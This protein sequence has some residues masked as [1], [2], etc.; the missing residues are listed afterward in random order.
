MSRREAVRRGMNQS[1]VAVLNSKGKMVAEDSSPEEAYEK[2]KHASKKGVVVI[3]KNVYAGREN[4]PQKARK[5]AMQVAFKASK[6][7]AIKKSDWLV[8]PSTKAGKRAVTDARAVLNDAAEELYDG[9]LDALEDTI[10]TSKEARGVIAAQFSKAWLSTGLLRQNQKMA[11]ILAYDDNYDSIGLSL[12]PHGASFRPPFSTST[13][14]GSKGSSYCAFSTNECRK[15]CLVNTGQRA[16]ESGAFAASYLFSHLVREHPAEFMTN[17]LDQCL[18]AWRKAEDKGHG[19]FIRLNVLSDL[20]WEKIAPGFVQEVSELARAEAGVAGDWDMADGLAFYDYTKIPYR[21]GI[22]G[23]YDVTYSFTGRRDVSGADP[24]EH[25]ADIL[26]GERGVAKRAA[27]VFVQ[28][29]TTFQKQTGSY[30]KASAGSQLM[31][32]SKGKDFLPWTFFDEPVWNGDKSDIRALDPDDVRVVG[33]TYKVARYK[34]APLEEGKQYSLTPVVKPKDI[35]RELPY[36][37]VRVMQP[38]P[39]A[40]PV[41]VPT[42]DPNNRELVLPGLRVIDE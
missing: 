30:Y 33:L 5:D 37:L 35:D 2:A 1:F 31:Q 15:A 17:L 27:V 28:R 23:H 25:L 40:P 6:I 19:R 26:D 7:P 36:F 16:L 32:A 42:Q 3:D 12:L 29:E 21:P 14:Q 10:H 13:K 8:D 4:P 24:A 39:D 18:K 34:V 38:D 20:P 41:V 11:K 9:M 22:K